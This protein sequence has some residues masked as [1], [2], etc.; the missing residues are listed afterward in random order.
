MG[1]PMLVLGLGIAANGGVGPW[2]EDLV[3]SGRGG[4]HIG[5]LTNPSNTRGSA[6]L[7]D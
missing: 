3:V 7:F 2:K 1:N 5:N 4:V 6:T